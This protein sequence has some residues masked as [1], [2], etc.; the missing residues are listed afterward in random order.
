MT[1][2]LRVCVELAGRSI[3]AGVAYFTH[4]GALTTAFRYS[5]DYL[6]LPGAYELDPALPLYQG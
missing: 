4:R 1:E 2:A 3:E 5:H 6:R